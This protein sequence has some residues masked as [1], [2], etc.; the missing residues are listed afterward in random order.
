MER[1]MMNE[2]IKEKEDGWNESK[3]MEGMNG[4]K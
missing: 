2:R 1:K 4:M 3:G